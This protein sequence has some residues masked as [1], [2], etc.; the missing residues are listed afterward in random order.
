MLKCENTA[1]I[2]ANIRRV[3][4]R[5]F[6]QIRTASHYA[7]L[8]VF[9][10]FSRSSLRYTSWGAGRDAAIVRTGYNFSFRIKRVVLRGAPRSGRDADIYADRSR[11][12]RAFA[13]HG[14]A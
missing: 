10:A 12:V 14:K 11:Q 1:T 5:F 6:L 3:Q 2:D 8:P 13:R 4:P 9:T 7:G